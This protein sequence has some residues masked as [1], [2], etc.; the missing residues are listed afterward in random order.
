M[1]KTNQP[2]ETM[3][4]I[5]IECQSAWTN[6]QHFKTDDMKSVIDICEEGISQQYIVLVNGKKYK[7]MSEFGKTINLNDQIEKQ[8]FNYLT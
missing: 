6:P 3:K 4:T 8:I 2:K 1:F 7:P 5:K